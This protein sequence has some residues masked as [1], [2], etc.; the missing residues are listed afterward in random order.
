MVKTRVAC[1]VL[2]LVLMVACVLGASAAAIKNAPAAYQPTQ[3]WR[4]P[5]GIEEI[6]ARDGYSA[7]N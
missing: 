2:S 6:L 3:T 1:A 5:N 7:S 4:E